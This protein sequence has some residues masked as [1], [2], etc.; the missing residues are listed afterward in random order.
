M[1][2]VNQDVLQ[3]LKYT[4]FSTP[5]ISLKH[6][7]DFLILG[8]QRTGTT[9]LSE[10]LRLHPEVFFTEPKELHFFNLLQLP[11]HPLY[12]SNDLDW[13]L[14]FFH[15]SPKEY[16][17]KNLETLK[18]YGEFYRP[19]VRGEGTASYAVL[20][21]EIIKEIVALNSNIKGIL[22]IRN[23]VM[24]AWAHAKKDLLNQRKKNLAEVSDQEFESFFCDQYQIACG[25]YTS[26]IENWSSFLKPNHLFIGFFDDLYEQPENLLLKIYDFLEISSQ[27]KYVT[28]IAQK[29]INQTDVTSEKRKLPKKYRILLEKIFGNEILE[30][31][32]RFGKAFNK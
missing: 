1:K 32:K 28:S 16:I 14:N 27:E 7:P 24:R 22:M 29:R 5:N 9:W 18:K 15:D 19:K 2:K 21:K 31:E 17:K 26:A 12:Q 3:Q 10:N 8:P 25:N 30:L 11:N 23:P 20:P 13:Y 6:F 4:K